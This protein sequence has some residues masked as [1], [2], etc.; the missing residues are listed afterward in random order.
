MT[1]MK[2]LVCL[3][4]A[5]MMLVGT[6]GLASAEDKKVFR[7]ATATE[8][9]SLDVHLG[10]GTW[11]ANVTGAIYECLVRRYNG[12]ILPGVAKTWEVSPD[13]LVYTFNLRE[14]SWT[15]GTPITAQTFVDSW[16]LL[17][18][19]ETAMTLFTEYFTIE[20]DGV[21]CANAVALDDYTLQVTL[22]YP[23]AF[24]MEIFATPNLAPV[25]VDLWR[26]QG[27]AY[28]QSVPTA[29]NGPMV[30]TT[31]NANDVMI[32]VPNE[33]YWNREAVKFD[34]VQIYTVTDL[35]TQA[36]MYDSKELDMLS[37]NS[38]LF[39]EFESKGMQ[40]YNDGS[41][42]F[43][44]FTPDGSTDEHSKWMQNR[45]FIEA[46]SLCIDR[47]DFVNSVYGPAFDP[48][49]EYIPGGATGYVNGSKA[50]SN[51]TIDSPFQMKADFD[52][53][54]EK[55]NAAL[56]TLGGTVADMPE[57]T[58][59]VS[60]KAQT[61]TAAQYIQDVCSL[62]DI[63][64]KI[65]TLPGAVYWSTLREGYRYDFALCGSGPDV[66]DCSTFL[67]VMDGKGKYGDTY[68]HWQSEEFGKLLAASKQTSDVQERSDLNVA[69]ENLL[70]NAGPYIP[71]Y[72]SRAGWCLADGFTNINRNATGA[73]LDYVFGD[74]TK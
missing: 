7:F 11:I 57:F 29:Q 61:Q 36:N 53:A 41:T 32:L 33:N 56:A 20:K 69:M 2:K 47:E 3:M 62:I 67:D 68:C 31:W 19:R 13:G 59:T 35:T 44:Q 60:D 27:D 48:A 72:H 10:N 5:I 43:L 40:Y 26:E 1:Y 25:R 37:V 73:D 46:V 64:I 66:D 51:V 55:L 24:M 34:E 70:L 23:V 30:L 52:K 58:L 28:Y 18:E 6:M 17:I 4:L 39:A 42:F 54:Q 21:R 65:D 50:A 8:P 12:E 45:D 49:V 9:T 74:Y 38:N 63:K 71:L 14:S 22:N 15:D 16:N